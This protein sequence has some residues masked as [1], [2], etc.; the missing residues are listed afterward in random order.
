MGINRGMHDK[1]LRLK[2]STDGLLVQEVTRDRETARK[3]CRTCARD[4][5]H[6]LCC[7]PDRTFDGAHVRPA[8][9]SRRAEEWLWSTGCPR[10][11]CRRCACYPWCPWPECFPI[12][13]GLHRR[14]ACKA[15]SS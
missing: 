14:A 7:I 2:Q 6:G 1:K 10:E 8:D 15:I 3:R 11:C 5:G 13:R 12:R 4:W 9:E